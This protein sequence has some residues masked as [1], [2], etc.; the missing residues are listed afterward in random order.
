MTEPRDLLELAEVS[1]VY[2]DLRALDEVSLSVP[3]GQWL[4][5]VGPSGSG[6]TT[7]MNIVGAMDRASS[8][9]VLLDGVELSGMSPKELAQIRRDTV[10]LIFQKFH[11]IGHLTALENVMV[12]QY[13][14][15][16]PD[17]P[18]A[19]AALDR[20]G[21]R[22]RAAHLPSQLS[23]GEQQRV[24]IARALINYPALILAD[25]PTGN[26]DAANEQI[27]LD[28]F[29]TLHSEGATLIVVTHDPDVAAEGQREVA[30]D[31][32]RMVREVFH[33]HP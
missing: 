13:Y 3:R 12:A 19:L 8:G 25:E 22:E 2:G 15:S 6:K 33:V 29:R 16:M 1:K 30:L 32:G 4:S 28:I 17:E 26:L 11:L 20:V 10:G 21:L 14:H 18:E 9:S 31:H 24:C 7:L 27:V 5:I 23:G